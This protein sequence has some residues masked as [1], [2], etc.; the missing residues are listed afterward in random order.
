MKSAKCVIAM[1]AQENAVQAVQRGVMCT[2]CAQTI[3]YSLCEKWYGMEKKGNM[4]VLKQYGIGC[5]GG[6]AVCVKV[7]QCWLS[8]EYFTANAPASVRTYRVAAVK[9]SM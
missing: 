3:R 6:C 2:K 5:T 8:V 4:T 1:P 9:Y 7:I